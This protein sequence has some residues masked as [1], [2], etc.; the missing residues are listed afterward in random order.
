[1]QESFTIILSAIGQYGFPLVLCLIL[2]IYVYRHQREL[3]IKSDL[4]ESNYNKLIVELQD[5]IGCKADENNQFLKK[6]NGDIEILDS[7]IIT[8]GD[9]VS[10]I[11]KKVDKI[12]RK[13]DELNIKVDLSK[14][15]A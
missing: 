3:D 15:N 9:K 5:K 13:V 14:K 8:I 11:D 2:L 1:M 4:R 10:N 7:K 12:D 6:V